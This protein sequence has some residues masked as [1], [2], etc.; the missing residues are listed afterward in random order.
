[1][2]KINVNMISYTLRRTVDLT[3][4]LPSVTI[5]ESL[6]TRMRPSHQL[7]EKYPVI[8]LLHGYGN[9]H[10]TW[11]GYSM[12]E[13]FAEERQIAVVM[14]SAENKAYQDHGGDDNYYDFIENELQE[15]ITNVFP[16]ST[17]KEDTYIAGLSMGG[18][19]T[20][21]HGFKNPE[22]YQAMGSFS[23]AT[24]M[25]GTDEI[26][27]LIEELVKEGKQIP[28]LYIAIG[29]DDF[30]L[31]KNH[32][33]I[34]LLDSYQIPYTYDEIPGYGHEWRFW[35][36]QIEKFMDWIKRTD[37]YADQKRKV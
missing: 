17:R 23:G 5:P 19:G 11:Q 18:F 13:L 10:A 1:M 26:S 9:N 16:I 22:K 21:Y 33:L 6:V 36:I 12:V 24:G 30:L 20:M 29:S 4:I 8:Y 31:E 32:D 2:A 7:K 15:Y 14:L 27:P 25:N 34:K 37:F 28:D 3:V 35:N